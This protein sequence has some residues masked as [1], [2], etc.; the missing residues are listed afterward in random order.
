MAI[1]A[2]VRVKIP[3]M[4]QSATGGVKT[5]EV[6]GATIGECLKQLVIQYPAVRRMLFDEGDNL[7]GYLLVILNGT[8]IRGDLYN[9]PVKPGD[10]IYPMILIEGG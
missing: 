5:A 4:F 1:A 2:S 10:E 8:G 3:A 7:S 6:S 9:I